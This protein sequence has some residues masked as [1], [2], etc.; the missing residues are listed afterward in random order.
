MTTTQLIP[1]PAAAGAGVRRDGF[2]LREALWL[3]LW[4][5]CVKVALHVAGNVVSQHA[6][7]GIFRDEMY[8]LICGQRLA[9]GYVDQP[10]LVA[11]QA[12][13]TQMLFGF[14]HMWSLR[15]FAALAGG[16]KVLLTGLL[17][18]ALGGGR[19]AA[20]LAMFAVLTVPVYLAL[21][22]YL[23][24]NSF[25]PVFW[26][27]VVLTLIELARLPERSGAA[28][29][30]WW[31]VLGVCAGVGLENKHT[32][33][34]YLLALLAG[35]VLSPERRLL[36]SR[37]CAASVGVLLLLALPNLWWQAAHHFPTWQWLGAV[38]HSD[39]DIKLPPLAMLGSQLL[40]LGPLHALLWVAGAGWL[41]RA[42]RFLGLGYLVF[43]GMMLALHAKDYYLAPAYP[44]LFA[45]GA[46]AWV[47]WADERPWRRRLV[48]CYAAVLLVGA[49]VLLP[50]AIPVLRPQ[51]FLAYEQWVGFRPSDVETHDP[52]PLPQFFADRFGWDELVQ[53]VSAIYHGLPAEEQAQT[54]IFVQNYGEASALNLYGPRLGL[55]V[56]ITGHQNY[57][58]WGAHGYTGK[59]MI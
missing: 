5:A 54:G 26:M 53:E 38:Q 12:R 21:D 14:D 40:M 13:L 17:V 18:R 50:Y 45:A 22:S 2:R 7:Y 3:G 46:V 29:R 51:R 32:L 37:W 30:A 35:L 24:M 20:A 31:L 6:G 9:A 1:G 49:S 10:P 56:A 44:V 52:T 39:K 57:W 48:W 41:L 27:L 8:Y 42:K 34:F 58:L 43:L 33:V 4:F 19:G 16:A 36:R 55:P 11:L 25:E 28:C 15:L 59:E 47:R 23:S